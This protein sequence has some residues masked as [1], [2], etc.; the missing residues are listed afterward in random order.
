VTGCS[1]G[2]RRRR[3]KLSAKAFGKREWGKTLNKPR[4]S[5]AYRVAGEGARLTNSK[6]HRYWRSIK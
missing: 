3:N 5:A 4:K 6:V 1:G 2:Q